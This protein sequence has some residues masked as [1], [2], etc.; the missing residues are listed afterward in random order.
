LGPSIVGVSPFC[1]CPKRPDPPVHDGRGFVTKRDARLAIKKPFECRSAV[2]LPPSFR[3]MPEGYI[4]R[5]SAGSPSMR[6][7]AKPRVGLEEAWQP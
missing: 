3:P 1:L 5:C 6:Q 7:M 4:L 2:L